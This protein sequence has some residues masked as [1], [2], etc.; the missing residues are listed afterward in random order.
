MN[1]RIARLAAILLAVMLLCS[2]FAGAEGSISTTVLMRRSR[3]T[4]NAVV[5]VGEDL[6]IEVSIEGV[7]PS[8]YQWYFNDAPIEGANQKVYNI[9]NAQPED[10]GVYRLDAFDEEGSMVVSMDVSARVLEPEVPQAG[11]GSV[12]VGFA[13]A[14]L[15]LCGALLAVLLRRR[16][17]A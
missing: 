13:F 7:S 14:G 12:P 11:D 8:Q 5:D 2:A 17:L 15:A 4:Q 16:R 3:M 10:T 6:S 1:G 9:V